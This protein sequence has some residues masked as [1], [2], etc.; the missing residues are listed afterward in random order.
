M[1]MA[2]SQVT[3]IAKLGVTL[4]RVDNAGQEIAWP[5]DHIPRVG[6][7]FCFSPGAYHSVKEVRYDASD[8]GG[9]TAVV[10]VDRA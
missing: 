7:R 1:V 9:F 8:G 6:D 10:V 3:Y 2:E 5:Y 4:I